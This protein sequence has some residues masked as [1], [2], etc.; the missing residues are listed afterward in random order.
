[1]NLEEMITPSNNPFDYVAVNLEGQLVTTS[2][3]LA[4]YFEKEHKNV[5]AD[6]RNIIE[7]CSEEF[8]RLNFQQSSY[9]NQQGKTQPMFEITKNGFVMV[10]MGYTGAKAMAFKEAYIKAFDAMYEQL[11]RQKETSLQ[12]VEWVTQRT[13]EK[14]M[15]KTRKELKALLQREVQRLK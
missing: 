6:I 15:E 4:D 1:M 14:E 8:G 7:N 9:T 5:L 2:V 11:N 3:T 10:A 12:R 13:V